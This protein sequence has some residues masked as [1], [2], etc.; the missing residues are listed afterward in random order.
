MLIEC[1]L[2]VVPAGYVNST[3]GGTAPNIAFLQRGNAG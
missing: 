2:L 3:F 1:F